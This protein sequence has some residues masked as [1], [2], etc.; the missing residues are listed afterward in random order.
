MGINIMAHE[1]IEVLDTIS[2]ARN[3]GINTRKNA[4]GKIETNNTGFYQTPADALVERLYTFET[5][6]NNAKNNLEKNELID[7]RENYL[8]RHK[9]I[10]SRK[11]SYIDLLKN[12]YKIC[13]E[14]ESLYE[15]DY[16]STINTK[17]NAFEQYIGIKYSNH[18]AENVFNKY[19]NISKILRNIIIKETQQEM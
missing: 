15:E 13:K 2:S 14:K 3:N 9:E 12:A 17:P 10:F 5:G 16:L 8:K 7:K 18:L 19:A 1:R 4:F 6:I 11:I